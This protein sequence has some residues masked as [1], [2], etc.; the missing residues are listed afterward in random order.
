LYQ[1]TGATYSILIG[2]TLAVLQGYFSIWWFKRH[3]QGPLEIIW[4]N[5]TWIGSK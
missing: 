3:K 1:Y 4:H 2:I 5:A